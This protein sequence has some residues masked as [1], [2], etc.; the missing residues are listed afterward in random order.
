MKKVC[1]ILSAYNGEQFIEEQIN[2]ILNQC[3]VEVNLVIRDD[4]STDRTGEII[5][6]FR[7]NNQ[8]TI[9]NGENIGYCNSF[10]T[11]LSLAPNS[12]YYAFADQD[13]IW[14]N[15]K[16]KN[17]VDKL[18]NIEDTSSKLYASSLTV[19]DEKL[20]YLKTKKYDDIKITL[21]S[22]LSRQRI[23]GCTM[24]FNNQLK[25]LIIKAINYS[26]NRF[27]H[28]GWA[29][30]LCLATGGYVVIDSSSYILYR[31]H[32]NTETSGGG[33][34]L[35]KLK[36]E[37]LNFTKYKN[38]QLDATKFIVDYYS[39]Y[40]TDD[41]KELLNTIYSYNHKLANKAKLIYT[42]KMSTGNIMIDI[43][44][45]IYITFNCF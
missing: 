22:A 31:R 14:L 18:E 8:V 24:V 1:V 7:Y 12:D 39:K 15:Q 5:K 42:N 44:N 36:R 37:L 2:S 25:S 6:K 30:L 16:L 10:I 17:A 11:A 41:S 3:E 20:N 9:I 43:I 26:E 19:V 34:I 33:K 40:L 27:G 35:S 29:Y 21:G 32:E 28:D 23:A 4:G 13:D 38:T 45:K